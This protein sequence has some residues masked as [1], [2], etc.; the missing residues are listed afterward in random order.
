M[1]ADDARKLFVGG[2]SDTVDAD[3][4]RGIFEG[5][6]CDVVDVSVPR[7]RETGRA[8][9]FAF[10]TFS[11]KEAAESART[12]LDGSMHAGRT[13]SVRAFSQ[14]PPKRSG[15]SE[16]PSRG[17][18]ECTVFVG[19]LPY[20]TTASELEAL[21]DQGDFGTVVRVALPTA[22]DG[23]PR[24]FGFV[25]LESAEAAALAV[26]KMANAE[27][28]GRQLVITPAQPRGG[29]TG[30]A[31]AREA[32][33]PAV[34]ADAPPSIPSPP[35]ERDSFPGG[36]APLSEPPG[37]SKEVGRRWAESAKKPVKKEKKKKRAAERSNRRERGGAG[38]WHRWEKWDED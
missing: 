17:G 18:E 20:E 38:S 34:R 13:I 7:D 11:S 4:L 31:P 22:S 37:M 23:R 27:L 25:T 32:R 1:G 33:G 35:P 26:E 36:D 30:G 5:A 2:L 21:F 8:R 16:R 10:V 28:R 24:G 14:D 15:P 3:G 29:R 6:G 12:E 19:K 9:G